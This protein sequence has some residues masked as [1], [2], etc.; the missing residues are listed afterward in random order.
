MKNDPNFDKLK[1]I[2]KNEFTYIQD[3]E[4]LGIWKSYNGHKDDI[5]IF[6][7]SGVQKVHLSMKNEWSQIHLAKDG[8]EITCEIADKSPAM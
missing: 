7:K 1:E 8:E 5:I 2:T 3:T 6:D 4:E